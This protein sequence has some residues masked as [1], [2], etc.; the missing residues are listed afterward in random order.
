MVFHAIVKNKV[1]F[2]LRTIKNDQIRRN[3]A[4][5]GQYPD[6]NRHHSKTKNEHHPY[7]QDGCCEEED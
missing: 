1:F 4:P 3:K 6:L 5:A 2:Y 7:R